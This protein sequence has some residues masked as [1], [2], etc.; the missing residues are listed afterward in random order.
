MSKTKVR[1]LVEGVDEF[2]GVDHHKK[3]SY[4]TIRDPQ[5]ETIRQGGIVTS[6]PSVTDYIRT[7]S[8]QENGEAP[9]RMAV[10]E[11]GRAYRPMYR[12]LKEEVDEVV[13]A[14]PGSLKI[15]SETVYKDDKIDSEKLVELLMLGV[16]P[17]AYA[18]SDEAWERRMILRHRVM[19]VRMQTAVKNRTHVVADLYPE[20]TP[21]RPEVSDLFGKVGL[22]WFRRLEIP[23]SE[24]WRLDELLD[25]FCYLKKKIASSEVLVRSIVREDERCQLLKSMP[26]IGDFFSALIVAEV[27]R[28]DR[29][30]S[31]KDFV[32]YIGLV[33]GSDISGETDKGGRLHKKGN[34]FLRWAFVEAA[35]PATRSNLSLKNFYDRICAKRSKKAGPNIAKC[36]VA[37]KLAEIAWRMLKEE[38]SYEDR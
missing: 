23:P 35:V 17:E 3:T 20:A 28:V 25:L 36:A 14:H 4:L 21:R 24:R 16:I 1:A 37:R 33:P 15:I 19:L 6:K 11:C 7:S 30:P 8:E 12:W 31:A 32:S 29:F 22:D 2:I 13:L 27:D 18:A 26:G 38:R 34:V 5:G 9:K 10:M